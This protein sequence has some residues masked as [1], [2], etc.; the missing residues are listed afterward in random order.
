MKRNQN[1][2]R[3]T[4]IKLKR[5]QEEKA[6]QRKAEN[7]GL[8]YV[9]LA[10]IY[11]DP[12]ALGILTEDKA[13]ETQMAVIHK[14]GRIIKVALTNPKNPKVIEALNQ[15]KIEGYQYSLFI[16]SLSGLETVWQ[17]YYRKTYKKTGRD[18]PVS[19]ESLAQF[20]KEI[21]DIGSLGREVSKV[22]ISEL[23][24]MVLAGALKTRASDI[25]FEPKKDEIKLRFRVD[26][27]LQDV[28]T[29]AKEIYPPLIARI[30]LIAG[31]KINV[32]DIPQDGR[33]TIILKES[34][35]IRV[36]VVPSNWGETLVFRILG[37]FG[38]LEIDQLGLRTPVLELMKKEI[39]KP[40]GMILTTGPTGAGKTTSLFSFLKYLRIPG[41]KIISL[42]DPIEYRLKGIT[43]TQINVGQGYTFPVGLKAILRQD[44]DIILVG[45]IRELETA[46]IAT[47]AALT[48]HLVFS[49]LSTNSAAET[50]SRLIN[51]GLKSFVLAPSIN[52]I[53]A[54]RLVRRVCKKCTKAYLPTEKERNLIKEIVEG[55]PK[56]YPEQTKIKASLRL[57]KG[58]GCAYCNFTGYRDRIGIFEI[59]KID[60]E[61]EDLILSSSRPSD[62]ESV[63]R[64][65]GMLS[66]R[67]DG[68]LKVLEEL[69]T[70]DEV[71][72]VTG[73]L[74]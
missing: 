67:E 3:R 51:M 74:H 62:I 14:K 27:I 70:L 52:V 24:E 33:F 72:R 57:A 49:T 50:I 68:I 35:D 15:L 32:Y 53:I 44:P 5:A 43:Q 23:L 25:H 69:T 38:L 55:I 71:E 13:R 10:K 42:E 6:A 17:K 1:K 63:A 18:L 2:A 73:T 46:E 31:L 21:E 34:I 19:E 29:L 16:S 66:L 11:T 64:V 8:P 47:N 56:N 37:R 28:V 4:L 20:E 61:I 26:G 22:P 60:Q 54:Q 45:E 30:K 65:K 59:L 7:L 12:E 58:K 40:Q 36:S 48:G 9:D 39:K 41:I